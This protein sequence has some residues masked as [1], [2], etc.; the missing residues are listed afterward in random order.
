MAAKPVRA[1]G[2]GAS[3]PPP[4]L[5]CGLTDGSVPLPGGAVLRT[6]HWAVEHC[7]GPLGV[8]TFVVKP[9]RHVTGVHELSAEE[10]AGLGPLLVRVADA[11]RAVVGDC[12][13]VYVCLWSH[14]GRVPG[15]IHFVV[16]P[17]RT[18]DLDRHAA[19]GPALQVAMFAEGAGPDADAVVEVCG[20]MRRELGEGDS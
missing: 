6:A 14:A 7:V 19:H 5:A 3:P 11:V 20:R 4:C 17:A 12:E 2:G 13:Q 9:L 10:A 16:Q 1:A 18:G 15:H 8:G